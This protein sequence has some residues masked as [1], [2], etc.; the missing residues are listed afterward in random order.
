MRSLRKHLE[1]AAE[2]H[3]NIATSRRTIDI[4]AELERA[5]S[6]LRPLLES[7]GIKMDVAVRGARLLRS[8]IRA[9]TFHH[10]I[11]IMTRNSMESMRGRRRRRI[12]LTARLI[13]EHCEIIVADNGPGIPSRI[14][15]R[16]FEPLFS[17]REG[18]HGMGLAV[19]RAIVEL[20]HGDIK[21]VADSRRKGA[22]F[23]ILLPRKRARSTVKDY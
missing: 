12:R 9:E 19:A 5:R 8:E 10:L 6:I 22:A 11:C 2:M 17:A 4:G 23:R 7:S 14:V 15:G 3:P 13:G 16:I 18:G 20:H 1:S 21:V